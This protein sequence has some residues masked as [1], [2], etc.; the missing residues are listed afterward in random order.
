MLKKGIFK[1]VED[2]STIPDSKELFSSII[3]AKKLCHQFN[4]TSPDA[5][6]KKKKI[7][8]KLFGKTGT[9]FYME[10]NFY[11][12][13][14]YNIEIGENFYS[15]HNLVI[16]DYA[17]VSFGDNV[18][19]GPNVSIYSVAHPTDVKG[20]ET[21]VNIAKPI[22]VGNNVWIGGNVAIMP[23]VSIGNNS[24]IGARQYCY[25]RCS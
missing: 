16:L 10:P 18:L 12:D 25:K 24:I 19:I 11:C 2:W 17:K 15:N 23:G 4:L 1:M 5:L 21:K 14:G 7:I 20:R 8:K 13:L 22:S 9:N 3:S 6:N